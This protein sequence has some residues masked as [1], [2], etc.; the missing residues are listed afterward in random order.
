MQV[1]AIVGAALAVRER[2]GAE[3][4]VEI[5]IPLVDYEQELEQMRALVERGR[6]QPSRRRTPSRCRCRSAR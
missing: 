4:A 5:M 1:R 3:P 2:T 6:A